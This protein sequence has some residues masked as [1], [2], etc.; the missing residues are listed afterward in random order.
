MRRGHRIKEKLL[1]NCPTKIGIKNRIKNNGQSGRNTYIWDTICNVV[2]HLLLTVQWRW[3]RKQREL[4]LGNL[5]SLGCSR[6]HIPLRKCS[7]N[8]FQYV[9]LLGSILMQ[10]YIVD[11]L[12]KLSKCFICLSRL[13]SS[14]PNPPPLFDVWPERLIEIFTRAINK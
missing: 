11:S 10:T 7:S 13:W 5:K 8:S 6:K 1:S 9:F 12:L 14:I 3:K 4:K 2:Y